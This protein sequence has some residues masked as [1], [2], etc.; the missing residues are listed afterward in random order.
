[1][2]KNIILGLMVVVGLTGCGGNEIVK[3]NTTEKVVMQRDAKLSSMYLKQI[4]IISGRLDG[5]NQA[6]IQGL[7]ETLD[8]ARLAREMA[9]NAMALA[10]KNQKLLEELK[11]GGNATAA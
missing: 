4:S 11:R 6:I 2:N 5:M 8:T 10:E 1:M 9:E 3:K 7:G